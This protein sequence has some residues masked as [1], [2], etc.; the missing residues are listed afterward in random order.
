MALA[1]S[2]V[3]WRHVSPE[4]TQIVL[5]H[6][7]LASGEKGEPLTSVDIA[8]LRMDEPTNLMHIHGVLALSGELDHAA[9]ERLFHERLLHIP[10]FRQRIA[11]DERGD[12]CWSDDPE[13]D[14]SRHLVVERLPEPADDRAL[15]N[16]ISPFL[17]IPFDRRYPLW[18]FRI[19]QG[20]PKGT[21]IFG[22]LHHAIG[23]GVALLMVLLALTDISP[24]GPATV[25]PDESVEGH[26]PNPFMEILGHPL[27]GLAAAR[28]LA[29]QVMPDTMRLLL[30][31]VEALQRTNR[32]VR[33]AGAVTAFTKLVAKLNDPKTA[34][35][36]PL[37]VEKRVW[38]SEPLPVD[39]VKAIGKKLG[40][41]I[42]DVLLT[43]MAGGLRRY[44]QRNGEPPES[45]NFR[46][47]MPVN[48][49]PPESMASLGNQF[50]LVFLSIPVGIADP[51][52]RLAEFQ[53]RT[54][55]LKR[56]AEPIV[57]YALLR[58]MGMVPPF[59]HRT[60]V[61]I[62]AAKITAVMTNVPGPRQT[63]YLA[64]LPIRDLFFWVPQ[65]GRVGLGVSIFSYA[66][67][68]RLGVGTDV[69]LVPDPERIVEGFQA[70]FEAMRALAGS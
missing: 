24:R 64:G 29:E 47:A 61:K 26:A 37:G 25:E 12:L 33:S 3:D 65:S 34:F 1:R 46:C 60:V 66:G 63:L 11:C 56:S 54:K 23:D 15:A 58:L 52:E 6:P 16:A 27:R 51:R 45:L 43:A 28:V 53:R 36:G 67:H 41:T 2:A 17:G 48:L 13:F 30:H 42:N 22:R 20:H 21:V 14:L 50:G 44:L 49:R 40:G 10:R 32:V 70:E 55:A 59:L 68:V 9:V 4:S 35:K 38:W 8:W 57:A 31:P 62:F 69:G 7:R 5:E 39:E 19:W 18:E